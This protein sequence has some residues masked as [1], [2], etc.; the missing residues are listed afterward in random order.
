[1]GWQVPQKKQNGDLYQKL[2]RPNRRDRL[3][4]FGVS[5]VSSGAAQDTLWK[6]MTLS[7]MEMLAVFS[8]RAPVQFV[9]EIAAATRVVQKESKSAI[10]KSRREY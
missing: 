7:P 10:T 6:S 3:A 1:M 9:W 2:V 8:T 5:P 4:I